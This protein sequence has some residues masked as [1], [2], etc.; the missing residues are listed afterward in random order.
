MDNTKAELT[1][2]AP[3]YDEL[4]ELLKEAQYL[5]LRFDI[6]GAYIRRSYIDKQD[7]LNE[8][9]NA[10]LAGNAFEVVEV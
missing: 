5:G 2:S 3:T 8:R 7:E 10:A 6:G 1:K 9:I 4:L